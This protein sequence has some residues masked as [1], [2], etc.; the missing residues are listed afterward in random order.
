[1]NN[2]LED[3]WGFIFATVNCFCLRNSCIPFNFCLECDCTHCTKIVIEWPKLLDIKLQQCQTHLLGYADGQSFIISDGAFL[4]H[5]SLEVLE[6]CS[7]SLRTACLLGNCRYS[8]V[9]WGACTFI[10]EQFFSP[11]QRLSCA[12]TAE[13]IRT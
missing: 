4:H 2:S 5:Y 6:R 1:M 3:L 7:R 10:P 13:L 11:L 12:T 9:P 8:W